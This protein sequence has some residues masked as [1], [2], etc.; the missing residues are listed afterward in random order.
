S[1]AL[2]ESPVDLMEDRQ[3]RLWMVT[4]NNGVFCLNGKKVTSYG[5]EQGLP[6][7][8][9]RKIIEDE[10]GVLWVGDWEG[11][12]A[13][14]EGDRWKIVRKSSGHPDAVRSMVASDGVIWIGTSAG[15]LLRLKDG[16][17]ARVSL[18]EGLP[19]ICVQQLLLDD[20]GY[21]WAGGSHAL[22]RLSLRQLHAVMDGR[23][24]RLQVTTYGRSDGL[25]D[26]SFANW[27]DPR[28]WRTQEGEL[29]FATAN[30]VIHFRPE[31]AHIRKTP[32]A[33]VEQVLL[34]GKPIATEALQQLPL[35]PNRL[36][37]RF[38]APCL[39]AP[40]RVQFRYQL[41]GVDADWVEAGTARS[42]TYASI[43]AGKHVFRVLASSPDGLWSDQPATIALTVH[44][45][46]WQTPWFMAAL[47]AT[48]AGG[49]VWTFRRATVRRLNRRLERLRAE[50]ALDQERARIAQDIHDELGANL[51]SIG[52]LA[53]L[54][55]R[56]K[57]DPA[58][59][60]RELEQISE[61]ARESVAAMDAIVWALNPRNDSLDHFANYIAH[62]TRDF[63]R[64]TSLRTRLEV[65]TDLPPH[66]L[67]SDTRH[68]LF[69]LVKETFN[70]I[71]RHARATEVHLKLSCEHHRLQLTIEDNGRGI[72][73]DTL[74]EGR[75]G[76]QNL[77]D[78]IE[79]LGGSLQIDSSPERGTRRRRST[80][81]APPG[82]IGVSPSKTLISTCG[83]LCA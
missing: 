70:N 65:P 67:S 78:R 41:T 80:E 1:K 64:P 82:G 48:F 36:E 20:R 71:V 17:S 3:G 25:P 32:N 79:R 35:G 49:G 75:N 56:N 11:G 10:S 45:S 14:L 9:I 42:A 61:T 66:A 63:F 77:K 44:S 22:F 38:T 76:L 39:S 57:S 19:D 58:K 62:F 8:F 15:G 51:T 5:V 28:S 60:A 53:D 46:F 30:G 31:E 16:E 68:Q 69:L 52:L 4:D 59:V 18:E 29:W 33:L 74:R 54:G 26:L 73:E 24:T 81:F 21:L 43:P 12:I 6:S 40:E 34:D 23:E 50:R 47:A 27:C 13:R 72:S 2:P 55:T 7:R 37:F 83:L